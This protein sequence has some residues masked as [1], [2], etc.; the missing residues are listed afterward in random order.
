[1]Q[2]TRRS[3]NHSWSGQAALVLVV[4]IMSLVLVMAF[5]ISLIAFT[6]LKILRTTVRSL[7]SYYVAEAGIEDSILRITTPDMSYQASNALD[8]DGGSATITIA[9]TGPLLEVESQG[10]VG[11]VTRKLSTR[12][13]KSTSEA[14]FFYG[15]QVGEGGLEIRHSGGLVNGNVFS[16]STAFGSGSV[17]GSIIV[18]ADGNELNDLTIGEDA[19]AFACDDAAIAGD[20]IYSDSGSSDCTVAGTTS[21]QAEEIEPRPLPIDQATVDNWKADA[22]A[23]GII[24]GDYT[25]A[26][27]SSLGPVKIDGDLFIDNGVTVTITGT[28][29]VTGGL[30]NGNNAV[31]QLDEGFGDLSGAVVI[32]GNVQVRNNVVLR[33][34]SSE[35]SYLLLLSTSSSV[36]ENNAAMDVKNNI[37]GAILYTTNGLMVIH[38]NVALVEATAYKLLIQKATVTYEQGLE[39]LVFSSGPAGGWDFLTWQE[40]E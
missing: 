15:V 4:I 24:T 5:G 35:S 8:V 7:Q 29:W 11:N 34:T 37:D 38:N 1:M 33:G 26:E 18:A 6:N 31:M 40:V 10:S 28:V 12:L 19:Q 14:Q 20:L 39:N 27:N 16:N 32:D 2:R 3:G 23:G 25:V 13:Q 17:T 22:A 21:T 30:D 36:D 9:Q